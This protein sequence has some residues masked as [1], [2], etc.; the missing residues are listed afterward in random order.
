M[1]HTWPDETPRFDLTEA[2]S[3][4]NATLALCIRGSE[5]VETD[6]SPIWTRTIKVNPLCMT[7]ALS[8]P[9][10][11][12]P[13]SPSCTRPRHSLLHPTCWNKPLY[14]TCIASCCI[15][16]HSFHHWP[17][18]QPV[19]ATFVY[20]HTCPAITTTSCHKQSD[21]EP[22][23]NSRIICRSSPP[24]HTIIRIKKPCRTTTI[25]LYI[26]TQYNTTRKI[27][28]HSKHGLHGLHPRQSRALPPRTTLRSQRQTHN[29]HH[30][31]P[32][33]RRRIHLQ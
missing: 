3:L 2:D 20:S 24:S 5:R 33:R 29:L 4:A 22:T 16:F 9:C 32:L 15:T 27:P 25:L 14:D 28:P 13:I 30:R 26:L 23:L 19:I 1:P 8:P 12:F 17:E 6:H 21:F 11:L 31:R 7:F 10:F 18:E